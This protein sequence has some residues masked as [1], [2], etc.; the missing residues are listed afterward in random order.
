M[1]GLSLKDPYSQTPT[2][3]PCL[4]RAAWVVPVISPPVENGAVLVENGTILAFGPYESVKAESPAFTREVDHGSAALMPALVNVHTHLELSKLQGCIPLPQDSF[5]SW[6]DRLLPFRR[7][8]S[9][10][11]QLDGIC[12][13]MRR[14]VAAGVCL[15]GDIANG[16]CLLREREEI[17][18]QRRVFV[19]VLGFDKDSLQSALDPAVFE[20]LQEAARGHSLPSLA[21][22]ACYSVSARI[23]R[24]AKQWCRSRGL[25]FSIHVAEHPDEIEFLQNGTGFCR[26]LLEALGRRVDGWVPPRTTPI[27]YLER[28]GVLDRQTLLVHAVHLSETDW[29]IVLRNGCAV[30]FCP[31]SNAN[32]SVG[33]PD[34]ESAVGSGVAV[35][36]GT[37]SLA[38]NVDLQLFSEAAYVLD[39]YSGLAPEQVLFMITMGGARALNEDRRFGSIERGKSSSLLAAALSEGLQADELF[40]TIVDQGDRGAWR[41]IA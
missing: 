38:S 2:E 18:L 40:E 39:N 26:R 19:E 24:E 16:P 11:A 36:L 15:C 30:C 10:E 9:P 37:D 34:V 27:A 28:L 35:S 17:P 25:V 7:L 22:H 32:L 33:R 21:A 12:E 6:L 20:A 5:A 31:R 41:W 1:N 13:G 29:E 23:I 3:L 14:L 4:H 8:L